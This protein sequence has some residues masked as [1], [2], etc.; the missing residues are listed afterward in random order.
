MQANIEIDTNRLLAIVN[1][2]PREKRFSLAI[3]QDIQHAFDY[4][5]K[6]AL[7]V[8]ADYLEMPMTTL[9]GLATF[10]KALSLKPKGRFAI[11]VC[12]G[13]ACHIHGSLSILSA[14]ESELGICAGDVTE[15]RL[16]SIETVNCMG[17]CAIA[18]VMAVG[19]VYHGKLKPGDVPGILQSYKNK[20][21]AAHES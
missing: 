8:V 6:D 11:K 10:Y 4:I 13:T 15:D 18:P 17:A 5:P 1:G 14:L 9:F 19:G 20:A 16:F 12:D 3:L 21:G 7:R 2:Y